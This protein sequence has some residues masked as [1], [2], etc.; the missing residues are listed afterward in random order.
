VLAF[1]F[2]MLNLTVDVIQTFVDPR[3]KRG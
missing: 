1:F 2:M 3:I